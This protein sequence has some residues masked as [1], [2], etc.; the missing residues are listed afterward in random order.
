[1]HR[2]L[3]H[4]VLGLLTAPLAELLPAAL[5]ARERWPDRRTALRQAHFP[6]PE[7]DVDGA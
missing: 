6:D 2:R 3:V 4:D 1:M 7:S 5:L